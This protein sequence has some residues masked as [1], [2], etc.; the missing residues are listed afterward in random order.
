MGRGRAKSRAVA[1]ASDAAAWRDTILSG[2]VFVAERGA[3]GK[4]AA[5]EFAISVGRSGVEWRYCELNFVNWFS[6]VDGVKRYR[7]SYGG[8]GCWGVFEWKQREAAA[9]SG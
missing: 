3:T 8:N 9:V 6:L 4:Q 5:D 2:P 7:L 1:A